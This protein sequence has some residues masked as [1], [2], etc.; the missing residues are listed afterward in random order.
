MKNLKIGKALHNLNAAADKKMADISRRADI[1]ANNLTYTPLS[2]VGVSSDTASKL[3]SGSNGS[4]MGGI[5]GAAIGAATGG[6]IG[7]IDNDET[8]LDGISKGAAIGIAAGSLGGAVS[9]YAHDSS[10]LF[11]NLREDL[12]VAKKIASKGMPDK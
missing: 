2:A 9:G 4:L 5:H 7:A 6:V 8:V 1:A 11:G 10:Y 12:A 3:A